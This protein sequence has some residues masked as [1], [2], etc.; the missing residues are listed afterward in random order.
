MRVINN[1]NNFNN[2]FSLRN[3][4][5]TYLVIIINILILVP[6]IFCILFFK[7]K[8]SNNNLET[9]KY[10]L[11]PS[12]INITNEII[13]RENKFRNLDKVLHG[14]QDKKN[15]LNHIQI[16]HILDKLTKKIYY[17][18][19]FTKSTEERHLIIGES[20]S[21]L[22][23]LKFGKAI[24]VF[25][26]DDAFA[27]VIKNYED[28]YINHWFHHTSF[29][30]NK[31]LDLISDKINKK[32]ILKGVWETELQYG[33]LFDTEITRKP[34]SSNISLIFP[35]KTVE[36]SIHL[37]DDMNLTAN[38]DSLD[39]KQFE[40]NIISSCGFNMTMEMASKEEDNE[41]YIIN[42]KRKQL[43]NYMIYIGIIFILNILSEML[44]INDIKRNNDIINCIPMFSLGFNI[45][46][47]IYCSISHISLASK[48]EEFYYEFITVGLAFA[49]NTIF[50]DFPLS[51]LYW[52]IIQKRRINRIIIQKRMCYYSSFYI[53]IFISFFFLTYLFVYYPAIAI[54]ILLCWTPQIIYNAIYY[55]KYIYPIIYLISCSFDKIFFGIYFRGYDNN[56]LRI[57]GNKIINFIIIGYI[58]SNLIILFLQYK[59]GPR[60][61]LRKKYQKNKFEPYKTKKELIELNKDVDKIECVI[62]LMPILYT[63]N[64]DL[65]I[66]NLNEN[67]IG[68]NNISINNQSNNTSRSEIK[69]NNN[70]SLD[71]NIKTEN[72]ILKI[73]KKNCHK[74][75]FNKKK[76]NK[77]VNFFEIFYKFK[78]IIINKNKQYM[79]TPCNHVFHREC[80]EKW[81][82]LKKECP[83][84]RNDLSAI[85]T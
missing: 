13:S 78:K 60:F 41:N 81:F 54:I 9:K 57:K 5:K 25:T 31:N 73:K 68:N 77:M 47:H 17:G 56:F 82:S 12:L 23:K 72:K 14:Y 3:N 43:V 51:C 55:N 79:I 15:T 61:F 37:I 42:T 75:I 83:N 18:K 64:G 6:L 46:W 24:Q 39:D 53:L 48:N 62:C 10:K 30:L 33:E 27:I 58:I 11:K 32:F 2:N 49:I 71:N 21:G 52:D 35:L 20:I 22:T 40:I 70:L 16:L 67:E 26:K 34:C 1:N 36:Y 74:F 63:E 8:Y 85:I 29:I 4:I 44:I 69:I 50:Y 7:Q 59:K 19:W 84:C 65:Y 76:G 38:F 66:N 80:L 28:N 45:N